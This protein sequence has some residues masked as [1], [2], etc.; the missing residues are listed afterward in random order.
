M[1]K[2]WIIEE[3]TKHPHSG[4]QIFTMV[5]DNATLKIGN[6]EYKIVTALPSRLNSFFMRCTKKKIPIL[7]SIFD[8]RNLIVFAP[9]IM[10]KLSRKIKKFK[11]DNINISSFAIA[12][13][14]SLSTFHFSFFT[15][16]YLHS[17]MQYIRS[18]YNEYCE[19]L[20]GRKGKIFKRI[21]P[22]LRKWDKK[23][24]QFDEVYANSNYTAQLAEELYGIKAKVKYPD[25][26]STD[27]MVCEPNS[28]YLYT[29][30]L[31]K[32]VKEVDKIIHL[33]NQNKEP[34]IIM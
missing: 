27:T 18:H 11:P 24:T 34:L 16:L 12:K 28:Y 22:R 1:L 21:T 6:T 29:G 32:F 26:V 8:Y 14:I 7:S 9:L 3:K 2:D 17:P 19:K 5:S 15:K 30:R 23:F 25:V 10:K 13:N 20:T 31:V 4:I 33:F